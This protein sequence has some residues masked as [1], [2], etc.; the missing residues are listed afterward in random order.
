MTPEAQLV[1]AAK[2]AGITGWQ[3]KH[4]YWNMKGPDGQDVVCCDGW[5]QYDSATG[6]KLNPTIADAI[7]ELNWHPEHDDGDAFRLLVQLRLSLREFA[8]P[9]C[10]ELS[11]IPAAGM[12]EIWRE[13]DD[14]PIYV[15]WYKPGVDRYAATR[16]A[17]FRAAVE[18]GKAVP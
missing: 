11:D 7:R 5:P 15:E 1:F 4:G 18:I 17:I 12:V 9:D 14:D 16:Q 2:A 6:R 13:T 3:S 8:P 10:E